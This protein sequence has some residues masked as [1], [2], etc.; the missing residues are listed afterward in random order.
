MPVEFTVAIPTHNRRETV[1]LAAGSC[2]RQTRPPVQV[3]VLADGCTDGTAEALRGLGD[4]RIEV[5]EL[6]KAPGYAYA[7]RNIALERARGG[8]IAYLGDDDMF[9]PDHFERIGELWD[10][11]I[12]DVVVAGACLVHERDEL[13]PMTDEWTVPRMQA[14]LLDGVNRVPMGA[15]SL[16]VE[17]ARRA[18]GWDGTQPREGDLDL[19]KRVL[20]AGARPATSLAPTLLH[21]RA[22]TR[23]QPWDDRVRQNTGWFERMGDP[24]ERARLRRDYAQALGER[25][26]ARLDE[27]AELERRLQVARHEAE[28]LREQRAVFEAQRDTRMAELEKARQD[29]ARAEAEREA[30][31]RSAPPPGGS[32]RVRR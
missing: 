1:L 4:D 30:L 10:A 16:T 29:F 8:V 15:V 25:E 19:W 7:H 13:Q 5:L 24:V 6:D 26:Q 14:R 11:G 12:A 2:L 22:T 27:I 21:F 9:L 32:R 18:G 28:L 3:I 20:R 31:A 23:D 17:L